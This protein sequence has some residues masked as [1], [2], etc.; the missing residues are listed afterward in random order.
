MDGMIYLATSGAEQMLH[1]QTVHANNLA[2]ASTPGFRSD[3]IQ[4]S[5]VVVPDQVLQTKTY[6]YAEKVSMNFEPGPSMATGRN[7]DV[8]L[9]GEGWI[10]IQNDLGKEAYTRNGN[11]QIN[12]AGLLTINGHLPV[13]GTGGQIIIPP[14]QK[15]DIAA[16]GT[17]TI[18]PQGANNQP[19]VLDR[20]KL[21]KPEQATLHKGNDG[22]IYSN[23]DKGAEPDSSVQ[24]NSGYLEG[25]NV[26]PI[27]AITNMIAVARQ[28]EMQLKMMN[29][30]HE[31]DKSNVSLLALS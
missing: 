15:M 25:S 5:S 21:V 3:K 16:D 14:N 19:V 26:N 30:A 12:E 31:N 1:A 6:A 17:I 20:I 10:A 8:S 11:L 22:L 18:I 24:L 27:E 2:N 29:T 28:F 9:K 4:F 7:L 13:L 23:S